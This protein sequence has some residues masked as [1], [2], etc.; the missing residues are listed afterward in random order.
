[1]VLVLAGTVDARHIISEL[2]AKGFDV[3]ATTTTEYG[4]GLIEKHPNLEVLSEGLTKEQIVELIQNR[5][6]EALIDA[7]HPYAVNA[8]LNAREAAELTDIPYYRYERSRT[9]Y[10]NVEV[11]SS[12]EEAVKVL[13]GKNQ[14]ILLT[15]GSNYSHLFAKLRLENRVY[16][17]VLPT[18]KVIEKVSQAGFKPSE[19][20]ALQ[21]PFSKTF[22]KA[23]YT[24]YNIDVIVTKDSGSAG[25][26]LE[27]IEAALEENIKVI[28]IDRPTHGNDVF[29][30]D[31]K[32]INQILEDLK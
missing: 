32:M 29:N 8:T 18:A 12:Y 4:G 17:R 30:N 27:K 14:N 26:T 13:N 28:L 9:S 2:L 5:H 1:M 25:G 31:E 16:T 6:I 7:T 24:A 21:G 15:I 23:I 20:I 19:I 11:V 10:Q 3:I 22:N